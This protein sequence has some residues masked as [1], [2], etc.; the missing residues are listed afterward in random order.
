MYGCAQKN[1]GYDTVTF[2]KLFDTSIHSNRETLWNLKISLSLK[3]LLDK[4]SDS[5][6]VNYVYH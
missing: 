4:A 1:P 2:W 6:L 3:L 5:I